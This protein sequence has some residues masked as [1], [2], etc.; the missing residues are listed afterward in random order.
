MG[1]ASRRKIPYSI[2][3]M[4][5]GLSTVG[6]L[7]YWLFPKIYFDFVGLHLAQNVGPKHKPRG[8]WHSRKLPHIPHN[9]FFWKVDHYMEHF[10]FFMIIFT[11]ITLINF[12]NI[13]FG[14]NNASFWKTSFWSERHTY[15]CGLLEN[16][17]YA[18]T[19]LLKQ[20]KGVINYR[21]SGCW[22]LNGFWLGLD[23]MLH[24]LFLD[25]QNMG[26]E[27]PKSAIH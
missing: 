1:F 19:A 25:W 2:C 9:W 18:A 16:G 12:N 23:C 15:V 7:S 21:I 11:W 5:N 8:W 26:E 3:W 10:K 24:L 6:W 14:P 17:R 20:T 13:V 4:S 22:P 27:E